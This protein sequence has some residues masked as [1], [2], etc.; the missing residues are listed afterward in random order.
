VSAPL[1]VD[2]RYYP[3]KELDVLPVALHKPEPVYPPQAEEQDISGKVLLR[4]HLEADGSISQ[5]DVVSVTPGGV[6][7]ELFKKSVQDAVR[8]LRF[9]PAKRNGLAVRA[10]VEFWI[11]FDQGETN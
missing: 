11:V 10:L 7:G 2:T 8:T 9:K 4:L 6:F 1:L 3:T 5:A